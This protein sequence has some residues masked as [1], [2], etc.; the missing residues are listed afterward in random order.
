MA[1]HSCAAACLFYAYHLWYRSLSSFRFVDGLPQ[2]ASMSVT[3]SLI[4]RY[5]RPKG[6]GLLEFSSGFSSPSNH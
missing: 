4:F 3:A 5:C 1:K 6:R 2:I